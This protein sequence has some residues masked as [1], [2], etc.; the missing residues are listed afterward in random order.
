MNIL[1]CSDDK[2][3]PELAVALSSLL[4]SNRELVERVKKLG[5]SGNKTR[6]YICRAMYRF[7][8]EK[9]A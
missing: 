7:C 5:K 3:A 8:L 4:D 2:Y 9:L 6:N 1:A